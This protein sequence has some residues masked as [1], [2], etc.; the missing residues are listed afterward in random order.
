MVVTFPPPPA[1]VKSPG[2]IGRVKNP[3]PR[4]KTRLTTRT[5]AKKLSK[6]CAAHPSLCLRF[7]PTPQHHPGHANHGVSLAILWF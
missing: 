1:P 6:I 3:Q 4:H 2:S 5:E 7:A